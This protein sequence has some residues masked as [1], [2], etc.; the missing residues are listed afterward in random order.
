M[1]CDDYTE[2]L[3]A[4][5]VR[6]NCQQNIEE[7]LYNKEPIEYSQNHIIT[8]E[9][10]IHN[11]EKREIRSKVFTWSRRFVATAAAFIVVTS[12]VLLTVP[13]V[14]AAV[15]GTIQNWTEQYTKFKGEPTEGEFEQ[16]ALSYIPEGFV[17]ESETVEANFYDATYINSVNKM[18][19]FQYADIEYSISINNE[20]VIYRT[21]YEDGILYY[22]FDTLDDKHSNSVLWDNGSQIFYVYGDLS[23]DDLLKIAKNIS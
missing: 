15:A 1:F 9:K 12:G 17:L 16:W 10:L 21:L 7:D 22:I 5:V 13:E 20:D 4:Q 14:R 6:D 11:D 23:V 3:F 18:F 19:S 8:M 2:A